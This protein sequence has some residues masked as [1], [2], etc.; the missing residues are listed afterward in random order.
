MEWP[1]KH[2]PVNQQLSSSVDASILWEQFLLCQ[3]ES[4]MSVLSWNGT[5]LAK[6]KA[7]DVMIDY[8]N[9]TLRD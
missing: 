2:T 8:G 1:W 5:K 4:Q 6:E 9:C 3:Q 7:V